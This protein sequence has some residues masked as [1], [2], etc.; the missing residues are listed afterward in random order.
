MGIL[1]SILSQGEENVGYVT[2]SIPK[3]KFEEVKLEDWETKDAQIMI[4]ILGS[5]DH[6]F[7]YESPT[8]Q[9]NKGYVGLS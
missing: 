3:P 6:R 2:G 1:V 5:V 4:W 9:N 7:F 8:L